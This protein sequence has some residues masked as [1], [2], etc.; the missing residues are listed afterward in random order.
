MRIAARI[1]MSYSNELCNIM[2]VIRVFVEQAI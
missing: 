1:L 2:R